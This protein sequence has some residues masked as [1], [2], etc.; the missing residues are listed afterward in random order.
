MYIKSL[1]GNIHMETKDIVGRKLGR[2]NKMLVVEAYKRGVQFEILPKKRF[3]MYH[4]RKSYTVRRGR[5]AE[6]HNSRL[7]ILTTN[8]KEVTSRLLRSQGFNAPENTVFAKDDLE[9]AWKWAEPILP[10]VV[11]PY[12]EGRGRLVFVNIDNYDEFKQC[13]N[14]VAE[15]DRKS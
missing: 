5:V 10:V 14:L 15:K 12:N 9:R 11:K 6:V 8:M 3:K 7:A 2:S 13:F 1:R 4:G